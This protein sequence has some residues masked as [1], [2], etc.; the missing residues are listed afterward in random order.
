MNTDSKIDIP[1]NK[2]TNTTKP[3]KDVLPGTNRTAKV[4]SNSSNDSNKYKLTPKEKLMADTY[5]NS[6]KLISKT[7]AVQIAYPNVKNAITAGAMASQNFKKLRIQAYLADH[8]VDSQQTIIEMQQQREDK[9]L[10]FDAARDIQDRIHGKAKQMVEVNS[11]AI[12]LSIDLSG[13]VLSPSKALP[14]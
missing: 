6:N 9:R 2:S 11:T 4:A 8:D 10:A 3:R 5:L 13:G 14:E 1:D 7:K 12:S